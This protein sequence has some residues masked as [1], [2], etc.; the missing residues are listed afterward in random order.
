MGSNIVFWKNM[1]QKTKKTCYK[2]QK[3]HV[4]KNKKN[5]LQHILCSAEENK[6]NGFG[7]AW[8]QVNDFQCLGELS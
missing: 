7:T 2:K 3:K 1:L 5:M 4:T 8:G 6:L